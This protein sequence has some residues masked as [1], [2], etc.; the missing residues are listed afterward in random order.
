[1]ANEALETYGK[2]RAKH[3]IDAHDILLELIAYHAGHCDYLRQQVNQLAPEALAQGLRKVTVKEI[4]GPE[5]DSYEHTVETV[6]AV[7]IWLQ[8]YHSE[9]RELHAVVKTAL[10]T[11]IAERQVELMQTRGAQLLQILSGA[12][13]R[14]GMQLTHEEVV[15]ALHSEAKALGMG[16]QEDRGPK[17]T[18]APRESAPDPATAIDLRYGD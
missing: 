3:L 12:A 7:N 6:T 10:A 8:L 18:M 11:G 1:M 15:Q 5:G 16:E 9:M 13:Q 14:L 2:P 17:R 4:T